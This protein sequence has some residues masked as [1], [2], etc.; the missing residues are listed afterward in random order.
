MR[1]VQFRRTFNLSNQLS[2]RR[3]M[4]MLACALLIAFASQMAA[5]QAGRRGA[6]GNA[7]SR[8][9]ASK[10]EDRRIQLL[11]AYSIS[12]ELAAWAKAEDF[13]DGLTARLEDA[14]QLKATVRGA[15]SR[16][17]AVA[18]AKDE[19]EVY[20]VWMRLEAEAPADPKGR[21]TALSSLGSLSVDFIVLKPGTAEIKSRDRV[22]NQVPFAWTREQEG[23]KRSD[24]DPR[25]PHIADDSALTRTGRET[26][27][28]ILKAFE[29][30]IPLAP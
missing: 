30:P 24:K 7:A 26:A 23:K 11:I 5:A 6:Q 13:L 4:L 17:E 27:D 8:T 9:P 21:P 18:R 1:I 22:A 20:V 19:Q 2:S 28:R 15:M 29:L 14:P 10:S 25:L 16:Q 12:E 3:L